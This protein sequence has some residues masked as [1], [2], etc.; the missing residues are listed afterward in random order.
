MKPKVLGL[1]V[2]IPFLLLG[3]IVPEGGSEGDTQADTSPYDPAK[4]VCNPFNDEEMARNRG[5]V[6]QLKYFGSNPGYSSVV[7]Y[8]ANGNSIDAN[9]FFNRLYVPTRPFDRG[10]V[11]K[12][13]TEILTERGDTLYEW[14]GL[15]LNTQVKLA[16]SESAGLYQMALL[17][18]DGAILSIS[19]DGEMQTLVNNDGTHPTRMACAT[20]PIYLD[21]NTK[22]PVNI[23][24]FQGPRYH[25]SLIVM[26]REWPS[27]PALVNDV[28]CGVS[29][30]D[31]FF[32]YNMNPVQ[33][34]DRFLDMLARGWKVL[35]NDNYALPQEVASNPCTLA[36]D[37]LLISDVLITDIMQTTARVSWKTNIPANSK[38]KLTWSNGMQS[39]ELVSEDLVTEHAMQLEGLLANT[40][41]GM[42]VTSTS[43]GGQTVTN[44][45]FAFKTRR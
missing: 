14:F 40:L 24:Y 38:I 7:D 39:V 2:V 35:Q 4:V 43:V 32:A 34:K 12:D 22:I 44:N 13:G 6:G 21:H 9:I 20:E 29:G 5:I 45:Q 27:D 30:N 15:D 26:W 41:Y 10:F 18:D 28:N 31:K 11:A 25:I 16:Q 3:C 33:P 37:P 17:S 8:V 42:E 1:L 19:Q 23:K 36:E